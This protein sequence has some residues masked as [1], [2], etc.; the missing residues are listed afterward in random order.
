MT[1][2]QAIKWFATA[3]AQEPAV[4]LH[5]DNEWGARLSGQHPRIEVPDDPAKVEQQDRDFRNDFIS[6]CPMA[7]G[8]AHVTLSVLHELGHHFNREEYL[9]MDLEEYEK[10]RENH[11]VYFN[12]PCE[13]VATEWAI[14][15]LQ[16]PNNRKIAKKFEKDFFRY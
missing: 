4:L 15:W 6:R 1:K 14:K 5:H 13:K 7:R 12:L 2:M 10:A 9:D 11:E 8:F 3:V 16:N